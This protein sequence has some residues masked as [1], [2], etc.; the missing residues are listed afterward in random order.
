MHLES[1]HS[2]DR[3]SRFQSLQLA[4]FYRASSRTANLIVKETMENTMLT[5]MYSNKEAMVQ[6][7][8]AAK[9]GS[10]GHVVLSLESRI[11]ERGYG[12]SLCSK[13][14]PLK[15][16]MCQGCPCSERT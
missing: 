16:G 10:F 13:G 5:K 7:R 15:T 6:P 4:W 9:P 1:Q 3:D 2:G 14:K 11:Q 8:Q 12:F